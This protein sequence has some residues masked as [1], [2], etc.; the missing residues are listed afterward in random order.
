MALIRL[1]TDPTPREL[2]QFACLLLP[3]FCAGAGALAW[4]H[5]GERLATSLWGVGAV[6]GAAG[7]VRPRLVRPVFL[8]LLYAAAPIGW[9][10]SHLV[11]VF[12]YYAVLTPIGLLLRLFGSSPIP[13]G[14][15]ESAPTYWSPSSGEKPVESY[16]HQY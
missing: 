14:F 11:M 15:D 1:K 10:V 2:R 6:V 13:R 3:L 12:I 5:G 16:F 9:V 4:T 8:G 7:A